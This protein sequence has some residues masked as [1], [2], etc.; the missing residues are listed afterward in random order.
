[1]FIKLLVY[2]SQMHNNDSIPMLLM[3][4]INKSTYEY[5]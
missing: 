2:I 5:P 3:I 4:N 1:M